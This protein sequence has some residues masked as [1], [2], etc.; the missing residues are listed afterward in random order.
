MSELQTEINVDVSELT[1]T[2]IMR[3]RKYI[4]DIR[5][6][7]DRVSTDFKDKLGQLNNDVLL[8]ELTNRYEKLKSSIHIY[9]TKLT[10]AFDKHDLEKDKPFKES[11]LN[12]KLSKFKGYNSYTD[13]YSFQRDFE[14]LH[15]RVTPM[16]LLP[17]LLK[18]KFLDEPALSLVKT[19][20]D[21]KFGEIEDG[22]RSKEIVRKKT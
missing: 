6:R 20:D 12:I 21:I 15:L 4:P 11:H 3:R 22:W 7:M 9:S 10:L 13:I 2:E 8:K 5:T 14:K 17:D 16:Y 1:D 19:L 18:N